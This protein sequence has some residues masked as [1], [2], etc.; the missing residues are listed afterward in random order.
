MNDMEPTFFGLSVSQRRTGVTPVTSPAGRPPRPVQQCCLAGRGVARLPTPLVAP[1]CVAGTTAVDLSGNGL[2]AVPP[3]VLALPALATLDLAANLLTAPPDLARLGS[4]TT[5]SLAH[6]ALGAVPAALLALPALT[7]LDLTNCALAALPDT[8]AP[9]AAPC[10][11]RL[12]LAQN[13][14]SA[15]P[16][17]LP[18]ACPA[19]EDLDLAHNR[20]AGTLCPALAQCSALAALS[21]AH[22]SITALPPGLAALPHFT[23]LDAS[24]NVISELPADL[25]TPAY[26]PDEEAALKEDADENTE[27]EKVRKA[28]DKKYRLALKLVS[29]RGNRLAAVPEAFFVRTRKTLA[30]ADFCDNRLRALRL[31]CA[32][33]RL[34]T[35]LVGG[36]ALTQCPAGLDAQPILRTLDVSR[37][38]ITALPD[39]S[40]FTP[41]RDLHAGFNPL[42][43]DA[44]SSSGKGNGEDDS[45]NSSSPSNTGTLVLPLFLSL[46]NVDGCGLAA[47][48]TPAPLSNLD[49]IWLAANRLQSV[50][51]GAVASVA[52]TTLDLAWNGMRRP[53]RAV[54]RP[55]VAANIEGNWFARNPPPLVATLLRLD[56]CRPRLCVGYAETLGRRTAQE[57][58]MVVHGNVTGDRTC[59]AVAVYDGHGGQQVALD[60]AVHVDT[61]LASA[62]TA[63]CPDPECSVPTR[64][65]RLLHEASEAARR[66]QQRSLQGTTALLGVFIHSPS[67][68][69]GVD[70]GNSGNEKEEEPIQTTLYV[71]NV[72]D[73]RAVLSRGGKAVALSR[74]HKPLEHGERARV[75]GAGGV[76]RSDGRLNGQLAVAHAL[77]DYALQP[78]LTDR[79]DVTATALTRAD[80]LAIFACDGLWDVVSAQGAV[81]IARAAVARKTRVPCAHVPPSVYA[82]LALRD[83]AYAAGSKDNISVVVTI[84]PHALPRLSKLPPDDGPSDSPS[85]VASDGLLDS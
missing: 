47:V 30:H 51:D 9:G 67:E 7:A 20:L 38:C 1:A 85:D 23:T 22:N 21:V 58:V 53:P 72:G 62:L 44:P 42:F 15:L 68:A 46:V 76:V 16:E 65:A 83:A 71:A 59:D 25:G 27:K 66:E 29:L 49:D 4:L 74:D 12:R 37:N 32:M 14:L 73:S 52:L 36:N 31:P 55:G 28:L 45:S 77:G 60:C 19:L 18:A 35:L 10:L 13:D 56:S 33:R 24:F 64:L 70:G 48:E 26:T 57:D 84:F 39:L 63:D 61:H 34:A 80:E 69:A 79:A 43:C 8:L 50:P 17:A 5:L 40:T 82:A 3:E 2:R 78:A 6:N 54:L 81:D 41:L 75:F 11:A